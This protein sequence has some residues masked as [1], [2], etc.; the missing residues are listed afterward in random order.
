MLMPN[1]KRAWTLAELH[2]LPDDGNRYE[3]IRGELFVTP[4]PSFA[5]ETLASVLTR[6]LDR[7]VESQGMGRVYHPRAVFQTS[8][9]QAEPDV[10]VIP[11]PTELPE[12]WA[13]A[14]R[15]LLV[16]EILSDSTRHRDRTVKRDFYMSE[17]IREYWIVDGDSRTIRSIGAGRAD[18]V[19]ATVVSWHPSGALEPL[20]IDLPRFFVEALGP[21]RPAQP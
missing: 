14:P 9:S 10:M 17:G 21:A 16:V 13:A 8:D 12:S 19:S 5:H 4:P 6:I 15:P 2:R 3:L 18:V 20:V 1:V 11:T 7:H